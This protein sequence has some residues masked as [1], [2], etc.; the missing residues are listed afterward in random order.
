[1]IFTKMT[2]NDRHALKAWIATT[3]R[4]ERHAVRDLQ[5]ARPQRV[6]RS[7]RSACDAEADAMTKDKEIIS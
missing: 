2:P 5:V 3:F 6:R 1:M 7:R 4:V